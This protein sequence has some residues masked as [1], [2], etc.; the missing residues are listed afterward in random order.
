MSN[1][2]SG[3][4]LPIRFYL[5]E[6]EQD[7]YKRHSLGVAL[8][9]LNYP[10]VDCK[11]LAPFQVSY[12]SP[13]YSELILFYAACADTGEL[14]SLDVN[15]EHWKENIENGNEY[16]LSYLGSDDFS[17]V[18]SNGMYYLIVVVSFSG[19]VTADFFSDMIM[20]SNCGAEND[21]DEFRIHSKQPGAN[22]RAIDVTDLRITK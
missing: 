11:T 8:T 21:T 16:S 1:L 20:I 6:T 17:G 13:I 15:S 7:R 22:F 5:K 18:L 3:L 12:D 2:E 9:E 19:E 10:Y 4:F 14:T